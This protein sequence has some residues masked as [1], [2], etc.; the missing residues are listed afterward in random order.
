MA[1]TIYESLKSLLSQLDDRFEVLIVDDGSTDNS[2]DIIKSIQKRYPLLRLIELDRDPKR[3]LGLTRNISI[4][5]AKGDYVLLHLD[6][7]DVFGPYLIDFVEVFHRLSTAF[8]RD[9]LLSGQHIN[10]AKRKFL[11]EHGP[12]RNIYRGEDRDLWSRLAV[13]ESYIP[14]DHVDFITRLPKPFV[15]K[16]QKNIK[17]IFDHMRN[18]FR[19]GISLY[20]YI[21]YECEKWNLLSLK[22]IIFRMVIMIPAWIISKYDEQIDQK[23]SIKSPEEFASYRERTRGTYAQLMNRCGSE[24]DVSFLDTNARKIFLCDVNEL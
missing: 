10:M 3:K 14:F 11:L 8:S 16:I 4:K 5:E 12:Y 24:V 7:D 15:K 13:I 18:D 9:I 2:V 19:G 17:D 23:N 6:C 21:Q 20:R 1:D 22:L